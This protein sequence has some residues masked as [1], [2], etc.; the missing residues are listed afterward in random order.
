MKR[1]VSDQ[2][3]RCT[4]LLT[5]HKQRLIDIADALLAR[6]ILDADQVR[7]IV[8]GQALEEHR[9][10]N[11]ASTPVTDDGSKR[12]AKERPSIVPPLPPLNQPLPQE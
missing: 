5:E 6:E 12:A 4:A 1:I 7:R 8:A 9:P 3:K 2:Y 11:S 10:P